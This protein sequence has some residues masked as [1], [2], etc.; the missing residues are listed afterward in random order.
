MSISLERA[1]RVPNGRWWAKAALAGLVG[2]GAFALYTMIATWST[3]DGF[4]WPLNLI[5]ATV[6]AYRPPMYGFDP[7]PS[8][9][10]GALHLVTTMLWGLLYGAVA[11]SLFPRVARSWLGATLLGLGWGVTVYTIGGALL[12]PLLNPFLIWVPQDLFFYGH[13]IYGL[14]TALLFC[15]LTRNRAIHV[16]FL[17]EDVLVEER[18]KIGPLI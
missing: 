2:G 14:T 6:P 1:E 13:L 12:G 17:R 5:G 7:G 16:V 15:A 18:P 11:A 10:G 4:W 9:V 8:L 3:N